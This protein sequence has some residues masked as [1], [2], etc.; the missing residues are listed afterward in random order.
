M[1]TRRG[2]FSALAGAAAAVP[3]AIVGA[4]AA[5][6]LPK[7]LP[8]FPTL[9]NVHW[10]IP[11]GVWEISAPGPWQLNPGET[12]IRASSEFNTLAEGAGGPTTFHISAIDA[13][14][15][16][17]FLERHQEAL[18]RLVNSRSEK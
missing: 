17:A 11:C 6:P 14:G 16:K 1:L 10:P 13:D 15:V 3:M 12:V 7:P 18:A 9:R 2:L 4:S 5:P 8:I